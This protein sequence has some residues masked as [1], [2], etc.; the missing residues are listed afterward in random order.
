LLIENAIKHN[1]IS[2][3]KPLY[4]SVESTDG[5]LVISNNLQPKTFV[6]DSTGFGLKTIRH[7]YGLIS[8]TVVEIKEET[9]KFVVRLP[10]IRNKQ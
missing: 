2:R 1:I 10:L 5:F 8:E 7:R 4:I 6:E 9:G 3:S